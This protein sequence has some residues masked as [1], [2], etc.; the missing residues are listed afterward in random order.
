MD[1][2]ITDFYE[3]INHLPTM[4][5][6]KRR[7]AVL[8]AIGGWTDSTEDKYSK[9]VS[10]SSS[11]KY[12]IATTIDFLKKYKFQGLH[13]DWIYPKCWQSDCNKGP[14]TDF[15]NFAKLLTVRKSKPTKCNSGFN[16]FLL[17]ST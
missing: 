1:N 5:S 14:D 12:F 11:R 3:R 2:L 9:L 7:A 6:N 16:F 13:F 17:N 4:S 15:K 8:L 10:D